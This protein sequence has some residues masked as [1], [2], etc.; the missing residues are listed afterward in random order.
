MKN[1]VSFL[2]LGF[3]IAIIF[4]SCSINK[5]PVGEIKE[6]E[7]L[8]KWTFNSTDEGFSGEPYSEACSDDGTGNRIISRHSITQYPGNLY[9]WVTN[10]SPSTTGGGWFWGGWNKKLC[11]SVSY[12]NIVGEKTGIP[13]IKIIVRS[14]N[15]G[16]K[17]FPRKI[18]ISLIDNI[19]AQNGT[20]L[21]LGTSDNMVSY[22]QYDTLF[23]YPDLD[24]F[25]RIGTFRIL[26]DNSIHSEGDYFGYIIDEIELGLK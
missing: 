7:V 1:F 25:K 2:S 18:R 4:F 16:V 14:T 22:E 5:N 24:D 26:L 23:F 17:F 8:I 3:L 15:D 11:S 6:P 13:Y 21:F 20:T 19:D 9:I 12:T 10:A